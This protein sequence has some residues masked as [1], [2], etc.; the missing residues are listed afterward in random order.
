MPVTTKR[1]HEPSIALLSLFSDKAPGSYAI[2]F[3]LQS[4]WRT[5]FSLGPG[6][7]FPAD[8]T[9]TYHLASIS[10]LF[11]NKADACVWGEDRT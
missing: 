8:G 4:D 1:N 2:P 9:E 11:E 6:E 10:N 3:E 5:L 7:T